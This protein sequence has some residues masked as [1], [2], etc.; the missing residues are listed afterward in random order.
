MATRRQ[1]PL[2]PPKPLRAISAHQAHLFAIAALKAQQ[3]DLA[4][5][6]NRYRVYGAVDAVA[7]ASH[8]RYDQLGQAIALLQAEADEL[9]QTEASAAVKTAEAARL[10]ARAST[11]PS[12]SSAATQSTRTPAGKSSRKAKA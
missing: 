8:V 11:A 1:L 4:V 3:R 9:K 6:A 2:T 10:R 12:V 5:D 7:L